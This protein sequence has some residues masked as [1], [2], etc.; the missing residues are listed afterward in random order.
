MRESKASAVSAATLDSSNIIAEI[1]NK[2]ETLHHSQGSFVQGSGHENEELERLEMAKREEEEKREK[3][4]K[5]IYGGADKKMKNAYKKE[6]KVANRILWIVIAKA[7]GTP[8]E[9]ESL[10][11]VET[12]TIVPEVKK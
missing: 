6:E 4:V 9:E 11:K 5:E 1:D 2:I 12:K 7:D 10:F 8:V 3:A